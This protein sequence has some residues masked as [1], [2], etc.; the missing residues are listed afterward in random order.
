[1]AAS[2]RWS[3]QRAHAGGRAQVRLDDAGVGA[4]LFGRALGDA[5]A[6]VEHGDAVAD[7]HDHAHVV[8]DEQDGQAQLGAQLGDEPLH[9]LGLVGVHA[10]RRLIQQQQHR[11][12][13]QGAGDLQ[14]ALVA[15]GQVAGGDVVAA[16]ETHQRQQLAAAIGGGRFLARLTSRGEDGVER[17]LCSLMCM[18]TSTFSSTVMFWKS[19]MFWKVRPM[20]A[21]T[22]S[23][24]RARLEDA[25]ARSMRRSYHSGR[26]M[27]VS[28][29][30]DEDSQGEA[31]H[32][33]QRLLAA[34]A[35]S[36]AATADG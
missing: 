7:A 27:P 19:R 24:G 22:M 23:F 14:A 36:S 25:E 21:C 30:S 3:R 33:Q 4:H 10:R 11:L 13:G 15:V 17:L 31:R 2:S 34:T 6:V 9:L 29:P 26:T 28:M 12:A 1:M 8:L 32:D 5:L 20:P 18:P 16:L 35:A